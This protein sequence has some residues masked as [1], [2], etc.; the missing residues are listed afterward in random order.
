MRALHKKAPVTVG[1]EGVTGAGRVSE[2][3]DCIY[4]PMSWL[5]R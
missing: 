5:P 2:A 4:L 1:E 3:A